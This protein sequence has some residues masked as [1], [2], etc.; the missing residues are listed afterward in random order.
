MKHILTFILPLFALFACVPPE[1]GTNPQG[2][3]A[4]QGGQNSNTGPDDATTAPDGAV[5]AAT[6]TTHR[7]KGPLVD[8]KYTFT[9]GATWKYT[10]EETTAIAISMGGTGGIGMGRGGMVPGINL[11]TKFKT[12]T[13]F[14][15]NITT[16]NEDGSAGFTLTVDSFSVY[17]MPQN[18]LM[19]S[20]KG[21]P[22]SGLSV[23]GTITQKGVVEFT[24]E[25]YVVET[26]SRERF[27]VR[28]SVSKNSSSATASSGDE[29]VTVYAK[30]D[31]K[32]G[33]LSGGASV[34]K[35]TPIKTITV[36]ASDRR[37]DIIPKRFMGLFRLPGGKMNAGAQTTLKAPMMK[38]TLSMESLVEG[39]AAL[40]TT[41]A[42]LTDQSQ[43]PE[44]AAAMPSMSGGATVQFNSLTGRLLSMKGTIKT[45]INS[46]VAMSITSSLNLTTRQ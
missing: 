5:P 11:S 2:N 26:K 10:S 32:S 25:L 18:T 37:M 6:V 27:L 13:D 29:E 41:L 34:K 4:P 28:A 22:R 31:P 1:G 19:A 33:T 8:L 14:T 46:G 9:K 16:V 42:A 12:V 15:M 3:S 36:T 44:G 24:E 45:A 39:I 21:L 20:G 40:K 7:G 38:I 17:A 35:I 43:L 30:F 23:A